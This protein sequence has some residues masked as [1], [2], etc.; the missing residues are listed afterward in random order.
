MRAIVRW[1]CESC[2]EVMAYRGLC[3]TCTTYDEDSNVVVPV[4]RVKVDYNGTPIQKTQVA[5]LP[6]NEG[7]RGFRTRRKPTK[8]QI[9]K[10]E[11]QLTA[12][13]PNNEGEFTLLG[14]SEEE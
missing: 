7:R 12:L 4:K 1:K 10:L 13:A 3:R 6:F 8:K 11:S 14:E 9:Q 5:N 2:G